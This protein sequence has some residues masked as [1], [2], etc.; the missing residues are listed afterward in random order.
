M[1][2]AARTP[3]EVE[4]VKKEILDT[5][6]ELIR[7]EGFENLSMRKIASRL[8]ITATTI[9][10]YYANKDELNLMI[11][12]RGFQILYSMLE[13]PSLGGGSV[14]ERLGSMIRAYAE[15]GVSH[16]G[17]Y[18]IMFNLNTPKYADY[19]GTQMEPSALREKEN[20][21]DRKSVV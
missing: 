9:Y 21:L 3:Q 13:E 12:I 8:R 20:A 15:F 19:A 5:A 4:A 10:N 6:L 1:P 17:Y 16:P 11:R 14:E 18:D 2:R 7:T